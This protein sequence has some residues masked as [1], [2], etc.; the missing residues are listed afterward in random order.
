[1]CQWDGSS[2]IH[3]GIIL[4]KKTKKQV[5]YYQLCLLPPS[6]SIY[7]DGKICNLIRVPSIP[8]SHCKWRW[9]QPWTGKA[10][11]WDRHRP[12]RDSERFQKPLLGSGAGSACVPF[13]HP[14]P[15]A[16]Q[17]AGRAGMIKG[18][19]HSCIKSTRKC[20]SAL[21]SSLQSSATTEGATQGGPVSA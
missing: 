7:Q 8:D 21:L 20:H 16:Q 2:N 18:E 6:R 12:H 10:C 11:H 15:A 1:M 14:A 13:L 3:C 5:R 4:E 17:T 19:Q 9:P